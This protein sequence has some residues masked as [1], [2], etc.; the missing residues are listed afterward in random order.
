MKDQST[1]HVGLTPEHPNLLITSVGRRSYLVSW[2]KEA[3]AGTGEVHVCNSHSMT[4][5]FQVAD[6]A[7]VSPL[8]YSEDYIPFLLDYCERNAIG[9]LLPLFDVDLPVLAAHAEE[10]KAIGC[11]PVVASERMAHICNDKLL[12]VKFLAELGLPTLRTYTSLEECQSAL[13]AHE[14]SCPVVI[15]PRWG[16]GSIGVFVCEHPDD[17]PL[18]YRYTNRRIEGSYLRYESAEDNVH[19]ILIQEAAPGQEWGMDIMNDLEGNL[20][21]VSVRKKIAMRSGETDVAE[22]VATPPELYGLA[23][24]ISE[25]SHH[26][27]NMDVDVFVEQDDDGTITNLRV[28][29]MNVRFGGGYPFSHAAGVNLPA[30]LVAWLKGGSADNVP[31]APKRLGFYQKDIS[32]ISL[33]GC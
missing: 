2:F 22:V 25:V 14:L 13:D 29:E 19:E 17:L 30:A 15:K 3:L 10:F 28:L 8:I 27:G 5:A 12:T 16:M 1:M 6:H 20:A 23:K 21:G 9:A 24:R 7:V 31:L 11:F 32:I 33:P 18:L 4:P 26:P